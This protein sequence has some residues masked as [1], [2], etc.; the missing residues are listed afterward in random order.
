MKL[1]LADL[2]NTPRLILQRLRYED[3]DEIFYTYASKPEATRYVSWPTHSSLSETRAYLRYAVKAWDDGTEYTFSVRLK[4]SNRLIGSFGIV[5]ED[6]KLQFGYVFSPTQWGNGFATEV[7]QHLLPLLQV[8]DKIYR[9]GTLVDA[10]NK[11][12]VRVLLKSGMLEEASLVK[13]FRF[14]N[15]DNQPKDCILFRLPLP[16]DPPLV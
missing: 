5:N 2:I 9:I 13:W 6:G 4:E 8:M 16:V 11:A 7:C 10:D 15:Q 14:I 12:S 3:A 1:P